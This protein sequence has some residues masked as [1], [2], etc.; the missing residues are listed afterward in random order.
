MPEHLSTLSISRHWYC[1]I[2]K[3]KKSLR[4]WRALLFSTTK[5]FA[6]RMHRLSSENLISC[7]VIP[8]W[9]EWRKKRQLTISLLVR[10]NCAI[11][12]VLFFCCFSCCCCCYPSGVLRSQTHSCVFWPRMGV[13]FLIISP[14]LLHWPASVWD[15]STLFTRI[16]ELGESV[17]GMRAF[18]S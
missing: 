14:R 4:G 2:K 1:K 18:S 12:R 6:Q 16:K 5:R 10:D 15:A 3:K 7:F 17:G 9:G 13:Y 11:K 8:S